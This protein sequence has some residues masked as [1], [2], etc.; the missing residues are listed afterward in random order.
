[1][2][3]SSFEIFKKCATY[4]LAY[5]ARDFQALQLEN[6]FAKIDFWRKFYYKKLVL[7]DLV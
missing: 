6:E 5:Q 1:M 2:D 7:T 3:I 4:D